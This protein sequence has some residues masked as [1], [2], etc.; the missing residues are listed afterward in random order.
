MEYETMTLPD[1]MVDT[2]AGARRV[3]TGGGLDWQIVK[4]LAPDEA[5]IESLKPVADHVQE[6]GE[7]IAGMNEEEEEFPRITAA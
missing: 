6:P 1:A 5:A 2:S 4:L 7:R 3:G